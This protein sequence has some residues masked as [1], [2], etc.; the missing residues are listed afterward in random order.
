MTAI[1]TWVIRASLAFA[2]VS[3]VVNLA[4]ARRLKSVLFASVAA[5][6]AIYVV[7]YGWLLLHPTE[8]LAWS[9]VMSGVS[10]VAWPLIWIGPAMRS[11]RQRTKFE[12]ALTTM[13]TPGPKVP[14]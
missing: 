6:S 11:C 9:E 5:L 13:T 2:L 4:A 3:A 7:S 14:A 12:K 8:R 1:A 10:L